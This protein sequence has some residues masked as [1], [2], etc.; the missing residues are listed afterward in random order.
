MQADPE[1][2]RQDTAPLH[3]H[4]L[5][6]PRHQFFSCDPS[7]YIWWDSADRLRM[8]LYSLGVPHE[9]DLETTGG[10]HSFDYYNC[11]A[12]KALTF[13]TERLDQERRRL[14]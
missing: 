9:C 4:L 1:A 6:W 7:D 2:A 8:K 3:I 13:I 10:G 14:V 5:N 12:G 11:M